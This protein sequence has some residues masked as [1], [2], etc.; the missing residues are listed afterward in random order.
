MAV[1]YERLAEFFWYSNT[2]PGRLISVLIVSMAV[3]AAI[4]AMNHRRR[5]DHSENESLARVRE[6]VKVAK[7]T[8]VTQKEGKDKQPELMDLQVLSDGIPA[9]S[10]IGDRLAALKRMTQARVKVNIVALQQMTLLREQGQLSLALP[11]YVANLSMMLG[12]LGTFIGLALMITQLEDTAA[13]IAAGADGNWVTS[14]AGLSNVIAGKKTAF[15]CTIVGLTA[16][17][18]L[19]WMNLRLSQAQARFYDVLERFTVEELLPAA[20]PTIEGET[21][22]ERFSLRLGDS[23]ERLGDLVRDQTSNVERVAAVEKAVG[24]IIQNVVAITK[25]GDQS[26]KGDAGLTAVIAQLSQ[27]NASFMKLAT[28]FPEMVAAVREG[29]DR[30]ASEVAMARRY[31]PLER[32]RPP[33]ASKTAWVLGALAAGAVLIW[34]ARL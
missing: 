10:L 22:L 16:S 34:L 27:V 26:T 28:K 32:P 29:Q 14:L 21:A 31:A 19:S 18:A 17:I 25:R 6:R 2:V 7:G 23:F 24:I 20:V 13:A 3:I 1:S 9:H 12:L 11:G 15:S 5:Y 4:Q 8:T 33:I 30:I